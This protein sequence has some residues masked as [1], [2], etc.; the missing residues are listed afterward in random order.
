MNMTCSPWQ[1]IKTLR[2]TS[3]P[4]LAFTISLSVWVKRRADNYPRKPDKTVICK[5]ACAGH[6]VAVIAVGVSW[7][8]GLCLTRPQQ[9]ETLPTEKGGRL[10]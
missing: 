5:S 1:N 4:S 10:W 9:S 8:L 2:W 7:T 6:A 3:L